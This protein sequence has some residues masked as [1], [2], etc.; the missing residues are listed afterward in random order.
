MI[1]Q[2][3]K[4]CE[5]MGREKIGALIVFA[6]DSRLDEYCKTGTMIDGQVS[7]QL[8]RN[9]FFPRASLHDGAMIIRDGRL[10]AAGCIL[11]LSSREDISLQL[12]TR[13]RAAIGMTENSDAVVLVVSEETGIISIVSNGNITRNYSATSACAELKRIICEDVNEENKSNIK[14]WF[15]KLIQGKNHAEE[16]EEK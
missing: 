10:L 1:V 6:R 7:E 5:I 15:N 13:H 9:V 3:V 16:G 4:A 11:P 2:T 8:I 12:G 14:E